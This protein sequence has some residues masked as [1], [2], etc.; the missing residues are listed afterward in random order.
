MPR[1]D[2][3]LPLLAELT[4]VDSDIETLADLAVADG[5]SRF[6]LQRIFRA[7]VGESPLQYRRRVRLQRA[8]AFLLVTDNSVLEVALDA[9][10]ASAE[11]F[12]RA[13]RQEFSLSPRA[14]RNQKRAEHKHLVEHD[15]LH[16]QIASR[17]AP[18][19]GLYR[20]STRNAS[21]ATAR[22][23]PDMSYEITRKNM[24]EIPFLYMRSQVRPSEISNALA[25]MFVPIFQFATAQG[26]AFAG[27][28]TARYIS[29]GPGMVTIEAGMPVV[30]PIEDADDIMAGTLVGGDVVSTIHKGPYDRLNLAHEAIQ[31]WMTDNGAAAGGAPWEAYI[32]DPGEVPN[33]AD[34]LTEVIHPLKQAKANR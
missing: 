15:P 26:I 23:R 21:K 33:P 14:F 32:T 6:H 31:Q 13:F 18:C 1:L 20:V 4:A 8:A 10:F 5:R 34:W 11:G 19:V 30:G 3:F 2:E 12:S 27:P 22:M 17:S 25:S 24:D 16:L 28:P 7:T 9:G 29:F